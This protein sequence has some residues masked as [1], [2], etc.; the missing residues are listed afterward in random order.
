MPTSSSHHG[1]KFSLEFDI[2][3]C[4]QKYNLFTCSSFAYLFHF[5]AVV[6]HF[7]STIKILTLELNILLYLVTFPFSG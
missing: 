3:I 5:V 7:I 4:L 6:L 1:P 2:H